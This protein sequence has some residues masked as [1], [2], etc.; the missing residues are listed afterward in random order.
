VTLRHAVFAITSRPEIAT[1]RNPFGWAAD[2]DA[3]GR[4][5]GRSLTNFPFCTQNN[6]R[7]VLPRDFYRMLSHIPQRF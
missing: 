5:Q 1:A 7:A 3:N 4:I 6:R 2:V